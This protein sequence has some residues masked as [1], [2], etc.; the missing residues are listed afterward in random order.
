MAF[1][2][3]VISPCP[4][5]QGR[6]EKGQ[7]VT[8]GVLLYAGLARASTNT[9]DYSCLAYACYMVLV[10]ILVFLKERHWLAL[11]SLACCQQLLDSL[12][13]GF[14]M[15]YCDGTMI[16]NKL[17]FDLLHIPRGD[18]VSLNKVLDQQTLPA[19][20]T[21][22]P[23]NWTQLKCSHPDQQKQQRLA[24]KSLHT[25]TLNGDLDLEF[26]STSCS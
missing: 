26:T 1:G 5:L 6:M 9:Q 21:T 13:V 17:V 2:L 10:L 12:K 4:D 25:S 20:E 8:L 24:S 18:V 15:R 3:E 16:T 7:A 19:P 14:V 11:R 22:E 23:C